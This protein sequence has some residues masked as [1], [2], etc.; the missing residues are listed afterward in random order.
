MKP[1]ACTCMLECFNK[2]N[3]TCLL[4]SDVCLRNIRY[5]NIDGIF[6]A[7]IEYRI[8]DFRDYSQ[9]ISEFYRLL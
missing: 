7:Y 2:I 6:T 5:K 1:V 4:R 3:T 8:L 9:D